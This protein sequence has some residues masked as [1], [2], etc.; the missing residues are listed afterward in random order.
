MKTITKIATLSAIAIATSSAMA[1]NNDKANHGLM[2][3]KSITAA[4]Q[5]SDDYSFNNGKSSKIANGNNKQKAQMFYQGV[6]VYGQSVV[7]E[8]DNAGRNVSM[9]GK[10]MTNIA[11][12]IGSVSPSIAGGKALGKLKQAVGH[13]KIKN[14]KYPKL[15]TTTPEIPLINLPGSVINELKSAYCVAVYARLVR[16]ER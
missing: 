12:D 1:A 14:S 13:A 8:K 2:N 4:M 16:L 3:G 11:A 10:L 9:A 6:K 7:L 5:L 15:S